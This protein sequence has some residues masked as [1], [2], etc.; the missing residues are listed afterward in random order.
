V[1]VGANDGFFNSN[2]YPFIARGW[3]ALLIEPNLDILRAAQHRHRHRP[4]VTFV[5]AAC[6]TTPGALNLTIYLDDEGGGHSHL[7]PKP[8]QDRPRR[9]VPVTVVRLESLLE[10]QGVPERFG[11]LTVDTEGHDFQVLAGANLAHF[12]PRVIITENTADDDAKFAL[13][14]Q[15]GYRLQGQLEYDTIWTNS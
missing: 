6:S 2:S 13:L 8:G 4:R 7:A 10:E 12:R 14:R 15:H 3:Q 11:L 1:N 5:N 9:A